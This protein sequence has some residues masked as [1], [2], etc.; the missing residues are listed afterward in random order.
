MAKK[1][2]AKAKQGKSKQGK[3]LMDI[4]GGIFP[5]TE[6]CMEAAVEAAE[7]A[8]CTFLIEKGDEKN[9]HRV[10]EATTL[11]FAEVCAMLYKHDIDMACWIHVWKDQEPDN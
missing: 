6:A 1:K 8:L 4:L 9:L 7:M 11:T 3:T 2:Q 10:H 5:D